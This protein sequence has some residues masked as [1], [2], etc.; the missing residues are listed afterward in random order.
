[1]PAGSEVI[2]TY[3]FHFPPLNKFPREGA[4]LRQG[5]FSLLKYAGIWNIMEVGF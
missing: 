1:M 3:L 5:V 2:D 4:L